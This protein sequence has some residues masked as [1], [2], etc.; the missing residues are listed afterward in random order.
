M[1]KLFKQVLKKYVITYMDYC[2][3][4]FNISTGTFYIHVVAADEFENNPDY[5]QI[6]FQGSSIEKCLNSIL[7]FSI[8]GR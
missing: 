6:I 3:N 5:H 8:E 7:T 2:P 4:D 1:E